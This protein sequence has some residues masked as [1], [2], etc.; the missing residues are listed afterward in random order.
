MPIENLARIS[1]AMLAQPIAEDG[2]VILDAREL[3]KCASSLPPR[4]HL[5]VETLFTHVRA[6]IPND[7]TVNLAFEFGGVRLTADF[8]DGNT[9]A[10][11]TSAFF[12]SRKS[13]LRKSRSFDWET[14]RTELIRQSSIFEEMV[15][16]AKDRPVDIPSSSEASKRY[17]EE[18]QDFFSTVEKMKG[19]VPVFLLAF[20]NG[21]EVGADDHKTRDDMVGGMADLMTHGCDILAIVE[22]GRIWPFPDIEAAKLE[23]VELLGPVSR[24]KAERRM[25]Y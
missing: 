23:A 20:T 14:K 12:T 21:E 2:V 1:R 18:M 6:S 22:N 13:L 5:E 16:A 4:L 3:K 10:T 25:I 15:E 17:V 7:F 19:P 8:E 9:E 24:A 11:A